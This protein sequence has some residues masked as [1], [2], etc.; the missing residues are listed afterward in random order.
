[1][2]I[3]DH[4]SLGVPNI[5][6]GTNFYTGLMQ[7]LGYDAL[8]VTDGFAAYGKDTVQFLIMTPENGESYSAGNGTHICFAAADPEAVDAFHAF[9]QSNG[10]ECAGAPGPREAYPIPNVYTAFVRDPFGNK[11]EAIANGF[12]PTITV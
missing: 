8:V 9:A 1:M 6:E 5:E 4:L 11:L 2:N 7:T 3:I 12:N 10:G